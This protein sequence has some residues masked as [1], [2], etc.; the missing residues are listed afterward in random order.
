MIKPLRQN[1]L[2]NVNKSEIKKKHQG[3]WS[4]KERGI[5]ETGDDD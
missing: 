4:V 1:G 3:E 5:N 2:L